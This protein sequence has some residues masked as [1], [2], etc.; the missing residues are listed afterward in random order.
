[1]STATKIVIIF[2][3]FIAAITACAVGFAY[4]LLALSDGP[5]PA[6]V[7]EVDIATVANLPAET[8]TYT[9]TTPPTNTPASTS[10][11]PT[12]TPTNTPIPPPT[13]TLEPTP[14]IEPT[15]KPIIEPTF[16]PEPVAEVAVELTSNEPLTQQQA[17]VINVVDGDTID[18]LIDGV[19]YR[20]RYI[21]I[22]TPETKHPSK[23]VEPFGPEAAEANRLLVEGQTVTLE[24]DVSETDQYGRLLR[25]V[26]TGPV[27]VQEELL[28]QGLAQVA[29]YPPDV[30][31]VDRFLAVQQAAQ[32]TG[33]GIWGEVPQEQPEA[34][35]VGGGVV[36][37]GVDKRAEFV[38]IQNNSGSAVELSGWNLLSERGSQNCTLGGSIQPGETLRVWAMAEDAGQGGFNCGF[39]TNIWN[40]SESDPAIL[41]DSAGSEV[42]RW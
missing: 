33:A 12:D 20:V 7:A 3:G 38:D 23:P 4:L 28:R 27:M 30:K 25:Y 39:G 42:S 10:I 35:F 22:D 37:V 31:Y 6:R 8:L 41:F 18:V 17:Q 14:T 15:I 24:K 9:P 36:I 13:N 5:E 32:N 40:N 11:P 29:T 2:T 34:P 19:E 26:Y 1:M 21:L 16:T